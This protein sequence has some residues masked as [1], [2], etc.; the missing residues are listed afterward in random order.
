M[1]FVL[2]NIRKTIWLVPG[3]IQR[4]ERYEY[5]EE[6]IRESIVNAIVHRDYS[7]PSKVQVRIFDSKIEIWNPGELPKGWTV[8]NLKEE[9]ESIP[10]NPLLFRL[11]FWIRY[12]E[13]VGGGTIDMINWCRD[14]QLPDPEF[15]L[16]GTSFVVTFRRSKLTEE[17][18][19]E[20]G[21]NERQKNAID[22]IK[23]KEKITN[24]EYREI[25]NVSHT[26]A[27]HELKDLVEKEILMIK[28]KGRATQY[29]LKS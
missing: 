11:L 16:T 13:D 14:F 26:L 15:K 25:N 8:E 3:K 19:K 4:E 17:Y 18:L 9:H 29:F 1:D 22:Y 20:L 7:F 21:L 23:E 2:R 24:R 12:V 10:M 28:G 27:T 5:P 6:A